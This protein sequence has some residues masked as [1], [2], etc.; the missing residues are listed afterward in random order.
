MRSGRPRTYGASPASRSRSA[1]WPI[2]TAWL[3]S[4]AASSKCVRT[5]VAAKWTRSPSTTPAHCFPSAVQIETSAS[6][7]AASSGRDDGG[8][9]GRVGH[10]HGR[11]PKC[12][13]PVVLRWAPRSCWVA[14]L[15]AE[16]ERID[17]LRGAHDEI[18]SLWPASGPSARTGSGGR[19][20]HPVCSCCWSS[21]WEEI[22]GLDPAPARSRERQRRDACWPARVRRSAGASCGRIFRTSVTPEFM[23]KHKSELSGGRG[24]RPDDA[25]RLEISDPKGRQATERVSPPPS[26]SQTD[27]PD[28]TDRRKLRFSLMRRAGAGPGRLR[29]SAFLPA[30]LAI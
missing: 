2:P 22:R 12:P 27:E 29:R 9:S 20:R 21:N 15:P 6:E 30:R 25:E 18:S 14:A 11:D 3:R 19:V 28:D 10:R 16:Q 23:P 17:D 7:A 26:E 8:D 4:R 24:L 13:T 5:R 1:T